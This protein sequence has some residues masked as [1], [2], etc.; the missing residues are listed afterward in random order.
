[1]KK[2]K[3]TLYEIIGAK[4]SASPQHIQAYA[5]ASADRVKF[6]YGILGDEKKRAEYDKYLDDKNTLKKVFEKAKDIFFVLLIFLL[7]LIAFNVLDGI[8]G[9]DTLPYR[10]R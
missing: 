1:M 3:R 6:A 8:F 4:E 10:Y 7:L 2:D 5:Q 9:G